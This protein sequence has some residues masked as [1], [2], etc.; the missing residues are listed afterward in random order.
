ML[1]VY[2]CVCVGRLCVGVCVG[3]LCVCV[4]VCVHV[5][6]RYYFVHIILLLVSIAAIITD[7]FL[8]LW[9]A[10]LF[11]KTCL[12]SIL[13]SEPTVDNFC[14][15]TSRTIFFPLQLFAKSNFYNF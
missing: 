15:E 7:R 4:C 10:L 3:F 9:Q 8:F 6:D 14:G 13:I 2:A 1:G 11:C 5:F 12:K